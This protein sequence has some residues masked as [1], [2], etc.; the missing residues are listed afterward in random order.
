MAKN[1][2]TIAVFLVVTIALVVGMSAVASRA[3]DHLEAPLVMTDGRM[4][5][6]DVYAF[7]SPTNSANTVLIMTVN[8]AAGVL[9]PT[10]LRPTPGDRYIFHID[11][12]GD[13]VEDINLIVR[14][15]KPNKRGVQRATLYW[16]DATHA[17][18][19]KLSA[20]NN[21]QVANVKGGGTFFHGLTDD[22]F[23]FDLQAFRDQV[24]GAGGSET[25]CDSDPTNFFLG[26]NVT[27]IAIEIPSSK[28]TS[29]G[30]S[31]NVWGETNNSK[32]GTFDRMG[33]PA[34]A[35][36][37]I[38]DGHEDQFNM[39]EPSDDLAVW[40]DEVAQHLMDLGGY[41]QATADAI[42]AVILPD[43]LNFDTSSASGFLNGRR[44]Q[45]DVIDAELGIVTN[46]AIT[47]DCVANDSN[48]SSSFPYLAP[49]N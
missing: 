23:F 20:G 41:D 27:S 43:T 18:M 7:Q 22:P 31:I 32:I 25:F 38:D 4:D 36:V 6:N 39:T 48:F 14:A 33:K 17:N 8:P 44:L 12:N 47:S 19:K 28:L 1:L 26:L 3:A 40:G 49:A 45:D 30:P 13:F 29:G 37:L 2:R 24:K 46:G 21:G 5:I 16:N 15:D 9:S 42:T 34:V 11:N 10:T 35:T